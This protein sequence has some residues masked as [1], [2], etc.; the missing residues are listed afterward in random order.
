MD[1]DVQVLTPEDEPRTGLSGE[2][3]RDARDAGSLVRVRYG[4][5]ADADGWAALDADGRYR[6]LVVAA[7]RRMRRAVF[8][9][10][11]AAALWRLP[12]LGAWPQ[13]VEVLV[14]ASSTVRSSRGVVRHRTARRP[15]VV[16]QGGVHVTEAARTVVD[17]ARRDRFAG[18]LVAADHALRTGIATPDELRRESEAAGGEPGVRRA[19]RVVTEARAE[20]ESPGESLSRARMI[21]LGVPPPVLQHE[22]RDADGLVARVDFWWEHLG[23]VGEFDGRLKYRTDGVPDRRA[24]EDRLWA[25][26]Q[27]EDRIRALGLRVVRWTW[28]DALDTPRLA[29]R[30]A[31][32][33]LRP[34][35]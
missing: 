13:F 26:K 20:A 21:E 31:T 22:L 11:S 4:A 19:R 17:L 25:E 18:A 30:L 34:A 1:R 3:L 24:V 10:A 7:S 35:P 16:L 8:S 23:L 15:A 5:Y 27:R 32:A 12:R 33:G 2:D 9:H 28:A 6:A 29:T 14:G